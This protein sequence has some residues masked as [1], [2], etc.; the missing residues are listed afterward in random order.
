[1]NI[2][3]PSVFKKLNQTNKTS[4][5]KYIDVAVME[6]ATKQSND[7][8]MTKSTPVAQATL[9]FDRTSLDSLLA[10][11][12]LVDAQVVKP[13]QFVVY[14]RSKGP[15]QFT[16][17]EHFVVVGVELNQ[18]D[19]MALLQK[20]KTVKVFAH[21]HTYSWTKLEKNQHLTMAYTH[22]FLPR[23][24]Y[25]SAYNSVSALVMHFFHDK[26]TRWG[27]LAE[28]VANYT[29]FRPLPSNS[30][31]N[32]L[33]MA[34]SILYDLQRKL[35]K[36]FS[37]TH[38]VKSD[39]ADIRVSAE[40]EDY[41]TSYK[42]IRE[43]ILRNRRKVI[44]G[45][46]QTKLVLTTMNVHEYQYH[47]YAKNVLMSEDAFMGYFDTPT[48]RVWRLSS[49]DSSYNAIVLTQFKPLSTWFEAGV[50]CIATELPQII[51]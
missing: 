15:S 20:S 16:D 51:S 37:F 36:I 31:G 34:E 30:E 4:M 5:S 23:Q 40:L 44:Y 18:K 45:K 50:L 22:D 2:A 14:D 42:A 28:D 25:G 33:P 17:H 9:V 24:E 46:G 29:N 27:T 32:Y 19:M 1:M 41:T 39:I 13:T 7:A 26:A 8:L 43:D 48:C 49:K 21:S 38:D 12:I 10:A 11:A 3:L 6:K 35:T 47:E